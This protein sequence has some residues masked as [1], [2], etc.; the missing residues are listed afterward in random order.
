EANRPRLELVD[1]PK[2]VNR[3]EAERRPT[4]ARRSQSL[5]EGHA[6]CR[7]DQTGAGAY[8]FGS[9]VERNRQA[10]GRGRRL[11]GAAYEDARY[12]IGRWSGGYR[13]SRGVAECGGRR[14]RGGSAQSV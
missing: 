6:A 2:I 12:S 13:A 4:R 3:D 8:R 1:R 10:E 14:S 5:P 11:G 9:R 7:E